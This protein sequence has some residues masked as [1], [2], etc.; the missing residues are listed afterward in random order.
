ME[1]TPFYATMGGQNADTGIIRSDGFE[2]A[3]SDTVSML[4]GKIGHIGTVTKGMVKSSDTVELLVD[5]KRRTAIGKNHS[6]THLL[7]KALRE[8]L[9]GHVEQAGSDVNADR[10]RFDFTHFSSMTQEEIEQTERIVNQK[11]A[12]ANGI[13]RRNACCEHG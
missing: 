3:V 13:V 4:G 11:I 2:F 1:E 5:Q 9:G 8:V 12:D 6:A 10:L 7:Q